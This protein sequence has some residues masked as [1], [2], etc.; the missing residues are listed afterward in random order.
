MAK[1]ITNNQ[2][3][4]ERGADGAVAQQPDPER[5]GDLPPALGAHDVTSRLIRSA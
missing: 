4:G 5:L 1:R 3:L 2:L